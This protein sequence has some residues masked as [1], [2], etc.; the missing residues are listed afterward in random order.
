[1]SFR[2]SDVGPFPPRRVVAVHSHGV[3]AFFVVFSFFLSREVA[4][5]AGLL[6]RIRRTKS[7][8]VQ[9]SIVQY[10]TMLHAYLMYNTVFL[11]ERHPLKDDPT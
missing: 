3:W 6:Q 1:M 4:A 8:A 2:A 11:T 5:Q 9:Y 7:F 10:S